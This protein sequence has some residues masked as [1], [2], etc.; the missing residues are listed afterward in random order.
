MGLFSK[1][2]PADKKLKELTGGFMLSNSFVQKLKV[3]NLNRSDGVK[4]REQL[5]NEIKQGSLDESDL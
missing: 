1:D 5:K 3:N 2:N 4:I